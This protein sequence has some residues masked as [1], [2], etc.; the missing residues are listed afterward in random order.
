MLRFAFTSH[1]RFNHASTRCH[2]RLLN[3]CFKTSH[4]CTLETA[5]LSRIGSRLAKTGKTPLQCNQAST[6][7]ATSSSTKNTYSLYV[8]SSPNIPIGARINS[9]RSFLS[10]ARGYLRTNLLTRRQSNADGRKWRVS[11]KAPAERTSRF[12]A[13]AYAP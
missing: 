4:W 6:I 10:K 11:S 9:T 2:V 3:S 12:E 13:L 1:S 8:C 7:P 5:A